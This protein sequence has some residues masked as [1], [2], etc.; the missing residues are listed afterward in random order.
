MDVLIAGDKAPVTPEFLSGGGEMGRRIREFDWSKTSL[1]PVHLW[2]QSLRT[3]LRIMLDSRQPIWIGWGKELIKL[4]NDPYKAIVGG[5]HPWALGKPAEV[6]WH[7]IWP[8]IGPMLRQVMEMDEGTYNESQFL[9]MERNGYP[10]ET[11]YTFSYTPIPGD[12]GGTAG[13]ICFNTDDTD[14]IISERQLNTLTQLGKILSVSQTPADVVGST[15]ETLRGNPYDFPLA[16]FYL[17]TGDRAWLSDGT[18]RPEPDDAVIGALPPEIDLSAARGIAPVVRDALTR[19]QPEILENAAEYLGPAPRGAW[20]VPPV[21]AIILPISQSGIREPYGFLLTALNPYRLPDEKY[22]GFFSVLADQVTS[23]FGN[24][25]ILDAERKRSRALAEIDQAKTTF[26]S[27]ISHEFRTP[28]TLLLG[29]IEDAINDPD[30]I[31]NNRLRMN[32]A[33][34]NALRMQKLVNTLLEFSRIEAGRM[35][36]RFTAVDITAY[37]AD[38]A[39]SFRSAI[40]KAGMQ[41]RLELEPVSSDIYVDTAMWEKIILNLVSNAFKYTGEGSITV[42]VREHAGHLHVSV[43]DTGI[44]I[45]A[46][47]LERVFDR[48][49]RVDNA[50]VRSQEGTGIGLSLVR[51]LV[52]IHQGRIE[53]ASRPGEGSVFTVVIPTGN[54][55]LPADRIA[56]GEGIMPSGETKIYVE[57]SLQWLPDFE[58][59]ALSDLLSPSLPDAVAEKRFTVL[60]ADDNADMRDYVGRLLA[61]QYHLFTA[62][63]GEEAFE[64][65][66][67]IKPDLVLTDVMMPKLDGFGLLKRIRHHPAVKM[68]PVIF[69]SARAGEESKVEGLE[70]GADD[71]LVKPFSA[72]EL[73]AR[74]DANIRIN[75]ARRLVEQELASFLLQ[76]PFAILILSGP[77]YIVD[78][79]NDRYLPIIHRSRDEVIGRPMFEVVPEGIDQGFRTFLDEIRRTGEPAFMHER[80]TRLSREDGMIDTF[81]LTIAYQPL[82]KWNGQVERVMI[83]VEDVTE[84]VIARRRI[85]Q[86]AG[87]LEQEVK[88]RTAELS[89]LNIRLQQSNEDLRQF[90]HVASHDLK[91]PVRKVKVYTGRLQEDTETAFSVKGRSYLEKINSAANRMITMIEGVLHYSTLNSTAQRTEPVDLNRIIRSIE[92]DL[93]LPINQKK[94]DINYTELPT[95]DGAAILLYQLFYNLIN[96]SLKFSKADI[97]SRISITSFI[98]KDQT[99]IRLVDNGIGFDQE[100]ADRIFETFSRLNAKDKYEGTG[101]GLSLCKKIVLRHGGSIEA[102]GKKGEG[103]VFQ[104]RLPLKGETGQLI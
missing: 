83:V 61:G 101:L 95:I 26:F 81:Y 37:T 84:T 17:I 71:Y 62:R 68:T 11:Y 14:R 13:M 67:T 96:N 72:R 103:S 75:T 15:I 1:G 85:E 50:A 32:V 74:V 25:H 28:L 53:V 44:G 27:N 54:A 45:P 29:P 97:P 51:E 35:E 30:D 33:Y 73:M 94:A 7:E 70:A 86:H 20:S 65:I 18:H 31:A 88:K 43:S 4:Y 52:R 56:A 38:L 40:E 64:K 102:T 93:E 60:L 78:L 89:E 91:E 79:A 12:D 23:S 19:K 100:Q 24:I 82:K 55:H 16:C 63:N 99:L 5:K 9:I 104:I 2:P 34:R 77:E 41:L 49:H 39:S 8:T 22:R 6:V 76:A 36:G 10:E 21:K 47:Q 59:P 48:F 66:L 57:E 87:L 90:A 3:C 42:G 92:T 98:D 58:T 69:L 46:D 80:E